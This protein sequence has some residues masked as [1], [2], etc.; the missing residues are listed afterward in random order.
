MPPSF[1]VLGAI[2]FLILVAMPGWK[3]FV[4]TA[5]LVGGGLG[6]AYIDVSNN[7]DGPSG[8]FALILL[9]LWTASFVLGVIA[10]GLSLTLRAWEF[11]RPRSLVVEA[12][13]IGMLLLW[14]W[15]YRLTL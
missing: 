8:M 9:G 6:L 2:P 10:R 5:V 7:A 12:V 13:A 15:L 14:P 4:V 11:T 1:V 3:S